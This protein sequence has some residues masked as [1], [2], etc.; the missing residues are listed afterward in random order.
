MSSLAQ[1]SIVA[2]S[3]DDPIVVSGLL[4]LLPSW[5]AS[6]TAHTA[7]LIG[8]SLIAHRTLSVG[9]ASKLDQAIT[10]APQASE[11][12]SPEEF[13]YAPEF[14]ERIGSDLLGSFGGGVASA[15]I[16]AEISTIGM[17]SL[18]QISSLFAHGAAVES[19]G[20]EAPSIDELSPSLAISDLHLQD[21]VVQ[22]AS[23]Q[24]NETRL[25][26]GAVGVGTVGTE[27]A[28][29]RITQEILLSLEERKTLVIWLFDQSGSLESQRKS[30]EARFGRIYDELGVVQA[31]GHRSF[32]K[33][34][35]APLLSSVIAFGERI[36]VLTPRATDDVAEIRRAVAGIRTDE[37]GIERTFG[38]VIKAVDESKRY[39]SGADRRNVM[40]V[41]FTD[42][43]GNDVDQLDAAVAQCRKAEIPVYCVGVPAPFGRRESLVKYIPPAGFDQ[44]VQWIPVDQGPESCQP[45]MVRI[46]IGSRGRDEQILDSGFGPY[47]LT[48]LCYETGGIFFAVHPNRKEGRAIRDGEIA[49][50]TAKL[51]KFFDP[52]VMRNYK[53]DY[54]SPREYDRLLRANKARAALVRAAQLPELPPLDDPQLV[55]PR[56][57]E[58]RLVETL[59]VAQRKAAVLEPKINEIYS[60]LQHGERDRGKLTQPRWQAGYD[61][62]MGRVLAAKVRVE[63]YNAMLAK[64]KQG[65]KFTAPDSD[66][67]VLAPSAEISVGSALEK[68]ADQARKLLERV[69]SEH[70]GTPWAELAQ[71]ELQQPIGWTWRERYTG[72]NQPPRVAA[73]PNNNNNAPPPRPRDEQKMNIPKPLP[74]APAPKL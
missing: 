65:M 1:E 72:V 58:A 57:N 52:E 42:E 34:R 32:A 71:V 38:A 2:D 66:T 10:T 29:D 45:E 61:L 73:A 64:A 51:A 20:V 6:L 70:R 23:P 36:T 19:D 39:R 47:S 28:I 16:E 8:M 74:K 35:D 50:L 25:V 31:T 3:P 40:L 26:R 68:Q 9:D 43:S 33:H 24:F 22:S 53:P 60:I 12:E 21:N 17:T 37:S 48:R 30:I 14:Q 63:A 5:L 46:S 67:W 15:P 54:V 27:G 49:P 4:G 59:L 11:L 41:I 62:A 44:T 55:F 69:A 7:L 13:A 18:N 56:V